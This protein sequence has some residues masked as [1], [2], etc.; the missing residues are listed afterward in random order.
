MVAELEPKFCVEMEMSIERPRATTPSQRAGT[1]VL[2]TTC[3]IVQ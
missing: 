2:L 1:F 3:V